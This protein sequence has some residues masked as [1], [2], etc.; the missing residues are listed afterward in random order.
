MV[1]IL[2]HPVET[3]NKY[4]YVETVAVSQKEILKSLGA[5]TGQNWEVERVKTTEIVAMGKQL[6][7]S[8]DF[9]GNFLLVQA[10]VWGNGSGLRQNFSVDESLANDMLGVPKGDLDETVKRVVDAAGRK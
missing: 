2:Q 5:A 8:G 10:S 3:A 6:V 7:A 4:L 1:S 9:T